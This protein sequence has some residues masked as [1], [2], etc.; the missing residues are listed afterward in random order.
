MPAKAVPAMKE[1]A[2]KL[3]ADNPDYHMVGQFTNEANPNMHYNTTGPELWTQSKKKIDYLISGAGTGGTVT[4][5]G[6]Y[7]KEKNP[8]V[9]IICVEPTESRV[10]VGNQ[11]SPHTILGIGAGI[12]V[13]FIQQEA[14]EQE[15][16]PGPRGNIDDFASAT[17]EEAIYWAKELA[18]KEGIMV[19]PSS[20]AAMKVA[21]DIARKPE[22]KGKTIV[23]I[24][25]SHGIRFTAHPLWKSAKEEA[26]EA[27]PVPPNMSKEGDYLFY[28]SQGDLP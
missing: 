17:S 18:K 24:S 5:C 15:L 1:Y 27:L 7:L 13:H 3:V 10:M 28:A 8:N 11:P 16:Q 9:K 19:G 12:P 2:E 4:G 23:F 22:S 25:A 14:P 20:G 21:I 6:R 26:A